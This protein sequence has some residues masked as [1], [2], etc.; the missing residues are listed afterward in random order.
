M[1]MGP[2]VSPALATLRDQIAMAIATPYYTFGSDGLDAFNDG[3]AID[4]RLIAE[5]KAR[6]AMADR[7]IKECRQCSTS[8]E[9][10]NTLP[11]QQM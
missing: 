9:R 5:W 8:S 3:Y 11:T 1:S 6:Y 7:I 10:R 4:V 2:K